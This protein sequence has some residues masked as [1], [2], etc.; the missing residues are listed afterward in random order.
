MPNQADFQIIFDQLKPILQ[1]YESNLVVTTDEPGNY[2][3]DASAVGKNKKP[4][5]FGAVQIKKNYV[6]FHLMLVYMYPDLLDEI[7]PQLKKRM[8]GMSCF[9]FSKLDASLF[10]ELKVLTQKGVERFRQHPFTGLP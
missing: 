6:S 9:N 5:F 1:A 2:Y 3:L 10:V 7:S 4:I 8:Q